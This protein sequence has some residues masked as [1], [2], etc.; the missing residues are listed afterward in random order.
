MAVSLS[1]LES[2]EIIV[3]K[4]KLVLYFLLPHAQAIN[5]ENETKLDSEVKP[6]LALAAQKLIEVDSFAKAL[7]DKK[8]KR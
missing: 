7:V 5:L 3:G 2:L 6:W 1:V 8:L 4:D